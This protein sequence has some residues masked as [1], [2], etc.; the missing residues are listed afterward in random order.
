MGNSSAQTL[1]DVE[2]LSL[3]QFKNKK[4]T[5]RKMTIHVLSSSKINCIDFVEYLTLKK[6]PENSYELLEKNIQKKLT[7]FSFM[8]Y[9]MYDSAKDIMKAIKDKSERLITN[10]NSEEVY[11]EV[12]VVLDNK[13]INKQ[14]E[15]IYKEI[16]DK[17]M[18]I[19]GNEIVLSDNPYYI[20]FL[21]FLSYNN[22]ELSKF[23]R[24]KTFQYKITLED[25]LKF[26]IDLEKLYK[27]KDKKIEDLKLIEDKINN[28]KFESIIPN[29]EINTN[30]ENEENESLIEEKDKK[31]ENIEQINEKYKRIEKEYR[32]FERKLKSLFSYY[33]ELGDIF[34]YKNSQNQEELVIIEDG[35]KFPVNINILLLG[36]SGCGKSTL[37]NLLLDEKKSIEG[38]NGASTTSKNIILFKKRNKPLRFYDVKGIENEETVKNYLKILEKFNGKNSKSIDRINAVFYCIKYNKGTVV[39]QMENIIFQNLIKYEIPIIFVITHCQINFNKEIENKSVQKKRNEIKIRIENA[40]KAKLK[41]ELIN[42]GEEY[43][44][45]IE[46]FV[47]FKYVN[48]VRNDEYE[49]PIPVFGIDSITSFFTEKVDAKF[50]QN[51]KRDVKIMMKKNV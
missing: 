4:N 44:K 6:I 7:L 26:K 15:I 32:E 24:S 38:G 29:E 11:S 1:E 33:N 2:C 48:L 30:M 43:D 47:K 13:D 37:I 23:I 40:I 12:V 39:E 35:E 21:I 22:L 8:N 27:E 49:T 19:N 51:L 46:N 34:S 14:I 25:I 5:P 10:Q 16:N 45:F 36:K 28:I 42:I 41:K 31:M 9:K 17:P 50:L 20:P 18:K 3:E